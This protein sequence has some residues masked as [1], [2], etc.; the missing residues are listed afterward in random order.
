MKGAWDAKRMA[1]VENVKCQN[2]LENRVFV[3]IEDDYVI[4]YCT[5]CEEKVVWEINTDNQH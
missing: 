5:A 4:F 1:H 2:C 3:W